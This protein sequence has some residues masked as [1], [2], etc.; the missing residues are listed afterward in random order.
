MFTYDKHTLDS[1]GAFLVAELERLD[2][3]LNKPLT[4]ITWGRDIDLR[5]DVCMG[6]EISSFTLS[7][8]AAAGGAGSSGKSFVGKNSTAVPGIALDI[9]KVPSPLHLWAM[10]L[11]WSLPELEAAKALGRNIDSQKLEGLYLKYQQDIDEMIYVGD[12]QVGAV[13][14]I[15]HPEIYRGNSALNWET[16][17]PKQILD[18]VNDLL[19]Q[20]WKNSAYAVVP[21]QLRVSPRKMARLIQP[22]GEHSGTSLLTYLSEQCLT[23]A[24]TGKPLEIRSLPR[25]SGRGAGG[26]DRT[27]AYTRDGR[28]VRFPMVPLRNTPPEYRG[29]YQ[30]MIFYC[31]LGHVE[32]VYP[33]TLGYLDGE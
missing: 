17:G 3:A 6:D 30:I 27:L 22:L 28:F 12:A 24:E 32:F 4:S 15:N 5:E 9:G 33:E 29:L 13:G 7:T 10:E 16:A 19:A 23:F 8:F 1:T 11:A 25:L 31:K 2:K 14:L 18:E 20:V 21:D 26:V